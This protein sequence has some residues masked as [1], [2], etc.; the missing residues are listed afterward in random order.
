MQIIMFGAA[1]SGQ[2]M[3]SVIHE[4]RPDAHIEFADDNQKMWGTRVSGHCVLAKPVEA[5]LSDLSKY[6][7][8]FISIGLHKLMKFRAHLFSLLKGNIPLLNIIH[9]TSHISRN[10]SLGEGNYI[11]AFSCVGPYS[12]IGDCNYFSAGTIIEHH[13]VIGALNSWGPA[14]STSGG[15]EI[16]NRVCFGTRVGMIYSVHV[17]AGSSIASGVILNRDIG[18]NKIVRNKDFHAYD[19]S[20]DRRHNR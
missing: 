20:E 4:T 15:C 8:A 17:G 7:A 2:V 10:A 18:E 9:P 12:Q 13:T 16:G 3:S 1:K 5:V 11:G 19:I 6:D 14:C